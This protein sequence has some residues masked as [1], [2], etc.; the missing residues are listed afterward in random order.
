MS[1]QYTIGSEDNVARLDK[2][3]RG[4]RRLITAINDLPLYGIMEA[5]HPN[6]VKELERFKDSLKVLIAENNQEL[7]KFYAP[8][9]SS[10]SS[11]PMQDD[12][13]N[14]YTTKGT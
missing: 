11:D 14:Q 8:E 13:I 3:G 6:L 5:T 10:F 12:I 7:T 9:D 2:R 1:N 4:F